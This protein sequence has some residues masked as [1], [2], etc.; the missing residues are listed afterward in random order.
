MAHPLGFEPRSDEFGARN[1]A[2]YTRDTWCAWHIEPV[3]AGLLD[4]L[5]AIRNFQFSGCEERMKSNQE[6]KIRTVD[7][8]GPAC[9]ERRLL[10]CS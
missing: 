8:F 9:V 4:M 6:S 1:V 10:L 2:S 3:L 7:V 5:Y